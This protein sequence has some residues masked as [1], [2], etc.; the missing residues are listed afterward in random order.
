MGITDVQAAQGKEMREGEEKNIISWRSTLRGLW[1]LAEQNEK[2]WVGWHR[3]RKEIMKDFEYN[4]V[5]YIKKRIEE[6]VKFIKYI[7]KKM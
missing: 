6:A 2:Y 5:K 4:D 7:L 3:P 1:K